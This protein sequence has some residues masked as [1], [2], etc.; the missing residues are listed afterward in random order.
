MNIAISFSLAG[1]NLRYCGGIN[2]NAKAIAEVYGRVAVVLHH[3][4]SVPQA[5]LT[6]ANQHGWELVQHERA[7]SAEYLLWRFASVGDVRYDA[8]LC[9]DI[10]SVVCEREAAAVLQ[11]MA[12]DLDIHV[13]RDHE[14]HHTVPVEGGMW[15]AKRGA[16][17]FDFQHLVAWWIARK[18]PFQYR[19][20][21]WFLHRFVWPYAMTK[22][23]VHDSLRRR[24]PGIPFPGVWE[25]CV[26][27]Y[28]DYT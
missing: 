22:A 10:D 23:L 17:P 21:T 27:H 2:A 25:P 19:S 4:D 7:T 26:G 9:R 11:W 24:W 14:Q 15:G 18:K 16:F 13:M 28:A 20:D 6:A 1:D 5:Y 8:V 3:D 12:S